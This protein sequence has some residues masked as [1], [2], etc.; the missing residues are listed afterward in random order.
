[1]TYLN[2]DTKIAVHA[3]IKQNIHGVGA[4]DIADVADISTHAGVTTDVHGTGAGNAVVGDDE[5]R[6]RAHGSYTGDSSVNRGI[7]HG[8][9]VAP[10]LVIIWHDD[11]SYLHYVYNTTVSSITAGTG[12]VQTNAVTAADTTNFYVGNANSYGQSANYSGHEL[13]WMA[14]Q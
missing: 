13:K 5:V 14:L 4:N 9:G 7:P 12:G 3:A 6:A 8:L 11:L 1:M 10:Y 2:A